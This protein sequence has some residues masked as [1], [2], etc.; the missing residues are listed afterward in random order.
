MQPASQNW[1]YHDHLCPLPHSLCMHE[2]VLIIWSPQCTWR[3]CL[4]IYSHSITTPPAAVQAFLATQPI[5][6]LQLKG[7][8]T[9]GAICWCEVSSPYLAAGLPNNSIADS[10]AHSQAIQLHSDTIPYR[11]LHYHTAIMAWNAPD[12]LL[13]QICHLNAK[14]FQCSMAVFGSRAVICDS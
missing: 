14:P 5:S 6:S 1:G 9:A 3:L 10:P 13:L 7:I 12:S 11:T 8:S 4:L 2:S